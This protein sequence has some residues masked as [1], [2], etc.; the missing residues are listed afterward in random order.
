MKKIIYSL[1]FAGSILCMGTACSEDRDSNPVMNRE[2]GPV[3]LNVPAVAENNVIDLL[4]S[5]S[6]QLTTSQ[7]DYGYTAATNYTVWVSLDGENFTSLATTYATAK[8]SV[9]ASEINSA[10]LDMI[11]DG[12]ITAPIPLYVKLSAHLASD[13]ALGAVES[14]VIQL[15]NVQ[16]Y[17]PV[18]EVT[19]PTD[20]YIVGSFAASNGWST[21]VPLHLAYSQEGFFYGVVYF[22]S[23]D[24]FKITPD[25]GWKGTDMGYGNS[26]VVL[27]G[28]V[29][30]ALTSSDDGNF[31]INHTGWYTVI[32]QAKIANGAVVYTMSFTE[33]KVYLF[34]APAGMT[35]TW[36]FDENWLFTAP[37]SADGDWV[38][39]A[40]AAA[41][42]VRVAIDCGID[43]WKT[44]CTL[45][46]TDIFYR[47]G[48]IP[49]N[50]EA[51][52]GADYSV[53]A[54][55]GGHI[56]LNFTSGTGHAE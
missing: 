1:L 44:E 31:I 9:P 35:D 29:A 17:V 26:Q 48:D 15:P 45:H 8:M 36:A 21:F 27:E 52:L 18:V 4:N 7:P 37:D 39:P 10:I 47:N 11:G 33:A 6:V 25:D 20:F 56:Y 38:S 50:W 14:N 23:G 54:V 53:K 42:E 12:D 24:Q 41:G 2:V 22:E 49:N 13:A 28:E 43:W 19:L 34:G 46:G 16:A 30:E 51:D 32:V 40:F 55:P 5:E 3:V